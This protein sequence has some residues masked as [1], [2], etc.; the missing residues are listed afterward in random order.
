MFLEVIVEHFERPYEN[1][2]GR[3]YESQCNK[4][5]SEKKRKVALTF[6]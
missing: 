2:K 1:D 4:G 5:H 6:L 3:W